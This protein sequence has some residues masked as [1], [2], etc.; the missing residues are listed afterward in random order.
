MPQRRSSMTGAS[1]NKGPSQ[2][3]LS[4][5]Q[6]AE[7]VEEDEV[8][9]PLSPPVQLTLPPAPST[10]IVEEVQITGLEL[11]KKNSKFQE[12][13]SDDFSYDS[14]ARDSIVLVGAKVRK[15]PS[16]ATRLT[17]SEH[18]HQMR[19]AMSSDLEEDDEEM[20][21]MARDYYDYGYSPSLRGSVRMER[22]SRPWRTR[23]SSVGSYANDSLEFGRRKSRARCGSIESYAND[24]LEFRNKKPSRVVH[25]N[26]SLG[27]SWHS[28]NRFGHRG[29]LGRRASMGSGDSS[30]GRRYVCR[31]SVT[32]RHSSHGGE[33][34]KMRKGFEGPFMRR[35]SLGSVNSGLSLSVA[36][37]LSAGLGRTA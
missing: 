33:V 35:S 20:D 3:M 13:E 4:W 7:T 18:Y 11:L 9:G 23:R 29:S 24:S 26:N 14:Y 31:G 6:A 32:R 17:Q 10:P 19:R 30:A 36:T 5:F 12:E 22:E 25:S 28:G 2:I 34:D 1:K 16:K 21:S 27:V 37:S 15:V 8:H